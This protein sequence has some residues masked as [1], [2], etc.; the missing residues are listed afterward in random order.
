MLTAAAAAQGMNAAIANARRLYEDAQS[1]ADNGRLPSALALAILSIEEAGKVSIIRGIAMCESDEEARGEWKRFRSHREKNVQWIL[2]D[3]VSKGARTLEDLRQVVEGKEHPAMLDR[4]KQHSFYTD[5][6]TPCRW[7]LPEDVI[8][9]SFAN[10]ILRIAE[11]QT[12]TKVVTAREMELWIQHMRPVRR[13]P[14]NVMKSA[15]REWYAAMA[16]EGLTSDA[17]IESFVGDS[18]DADRTH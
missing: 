7:I 10:S 5:C 11:I 17:G 4:I 8:P 16:R 14:L 2:A 12:R 1:L 18:T 6:L 13:A 3:L 9:D 15:L